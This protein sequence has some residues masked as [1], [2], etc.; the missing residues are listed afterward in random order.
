M[1][2]VH[3]HITLEGAAAFGN[4]LE[5]FRAPDL[6]H[7]IMINALK[8]ERFSK[9]VALPQIVY[10]ILPQLEFRSKKAF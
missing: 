4:F 8:I 5:I 10:N 6:S 7:Y 2:T 3:P 9:E 1:P